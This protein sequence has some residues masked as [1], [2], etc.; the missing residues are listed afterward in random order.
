MPLIK[1]AKKKLRQDKKR[2][3]R[4]RS[5]KDFFKEVLKTARENPTNES[6]TKAFKAADK[7]AKKHIMHRN[8]AARIKSSLSKLIARKE[9]LA[10][11]KTIAKKTKK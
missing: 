6:V 8:K 3:K 1:S 11:K 5:T 2:Q 7:A 9:Q 4:N 10:P